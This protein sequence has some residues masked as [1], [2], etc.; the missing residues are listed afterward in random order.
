MTVRAIER[1]SVEREEVPPAPA[2]RVVEGPP[3]PVVPEAAPLP[4]EPPQTAPEAPLGPSIWEAAAIQ[5]V[6]ITTGIAEILSI[7]FALTL[8]IIASAFLTFFA[9]TQREHQLLAVVAAALFT[10]PSLT[11]MVALALRKG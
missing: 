6:A 11:L 8:T 3:A 1:L 7:R 9:E 4:Q 5:A 10:I 2:L